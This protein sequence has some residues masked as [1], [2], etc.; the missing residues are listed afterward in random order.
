MT[1]LRR[2][3]VTIF[4]A[5]ALLSALIVS[6]QAVMTSLTVKSGEEFVCPLNLVLDDR[7]LIQYTTVG[8]KNNGLQFSM[9]IPNGTV[10]DFGTSGDFTYTFVCGTKG[11][12]LLTFVNLDELDV[13]LTLEYEID[14]YI[15]GMPQMLFMVVLIVVISLAGV[16]AFIG[17]SRKPY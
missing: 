5:L 16:A 4:V 8:G 11:E 3:L 10:R 2:S 9:K 12:Y 14:H 15:F 6:C 17:L 7:V 13:L 1:N